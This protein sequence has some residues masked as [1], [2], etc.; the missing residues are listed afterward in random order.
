M[1]PQPQQVAVV[2]CEPVASLLLLLDVRTLVDMLV[3]AVVLM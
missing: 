3:L 2:L 1:R